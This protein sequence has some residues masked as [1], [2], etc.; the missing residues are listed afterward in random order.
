MSRAAQNKVTRIIYVTLLVFLLLVF[1]SPFVI[2]IMFAGTVALAMFPL[3]VRLE[4]RG[5]SRRLASAIL[6]TLFTIVISIPLFFFLIKGTVVVTGQLEKMSFNE[7]LREDGMTGLVTDLRHDLVLSV[8][9]IAQKFDVSDF[10]TAK[11]IDSYLAMVNSYLLKFFQD[12]ATQIPVVVLFFIIMIL[13]TY[14]FLKNAQGVKNF[15]QKVFGFDDEKMDTLVEI[16]IRDSRQVYI[17]N[18]TTG[19]VQAVLVALGG[20]ILGIADFFFIF[21]VTLILSFVP[22]IGASPVAFML[23]L[24]AFF[25]GETTHAIILVVLGAVTGVVDN[26]MRPWLASFGESHIPPIVSFVCVIGGALLLGFPGLFIGILVGS[27]A[28]DTLPLF[29]EELAKSNLK[30]KP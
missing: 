14:S 10:L 12:F 27:I 30:E 1:V 3:L 25:K 29:W 20:M 2:P 8:Q 15:A 19:A 23:A 18:I 5:L 22:V 11:K 26:I 7:K 21:F 13:C 24:V 9:K 16:Y 28:Y 17:S 4:K 6:T